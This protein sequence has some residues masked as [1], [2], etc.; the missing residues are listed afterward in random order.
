MAQ[1]IIK[2]VTSLALAAVILFTA[3]CGNSNRGN[4]PSAENE[5]R[6]ENESG[7]SD[8]AMGRFV[9]EEIDLSENLTNVREL[10]KFSDGKLMIIDASSGIWVSNDN[11][12]SWQD[13]NTEYLE[14]K[15]T[16]AYIMD[17]RAGED[18]TLGIIYD[19]YEDELSTE[20]EDEREN[21]SKD[22]EEL[23]EGRED[24]N[25]EEFSE[26]ADSAFNLSPEC[27]LVK[28]DGTVIPVSL[29]LT[30]DEMYANRMWMTK[31]GRTF[32][33]TLGNIIYEVKED[34]SSEEFLTMEG[35][36]MLI[37]FGENIMLIDGYDF[38]A[39]LLYDM[40]KK[41]YVEDDVLTD[42]VKEQAA[43]RQFNGGSWY[44]LYY[45]FGEDEKL[46]L[47]GE[48]GLYRHGAGQEEMDQLIDGSLS[49]LGSP[50]YG[51]KGMVMMEDETFLAVFN[52]GKV[53]R[54]TYDPNMPSM[55]EESLKVYS[56]EDSY[57]IRTAIA[58]YQ[59][60]K[61]NVH[62]E[63]EIGRGEDNGVTREDALKKL[64]TQIMA[65]EG[66]D[67]LM[68]DGLPVDSYIEK[69]LLLDLNEFLEDVF[70]EEEL[71]ENLIRAFAYEGS[72]YTIPMQAGFPVMLGR[73]GY[74]SEMKDLASVADEMEK[75]RKDYP[76]N[77]ILGIC[78]E[79]M[80]MKI[81]SVSSAPA[82]K[83]ENGEINEDALAEFLIQMKR[84]Y[85]AQMDGIDQKWVAKFE[86]T[87]DWYAEELGENWEYNLGMYGVNTLDYVGEYTRFMAGMTT[88]PYGYYDI[89][90]AAKT[91]GFEDTVLTPM[92][93]QCSNVF[94]PDT[95]L[96]IN[97]ASAKKELAEDFLKEFLGKEVQ[98][99]LGG[100]GINKE[101]FNEMLTVDGKDLGENNQYGSMAMM[102]EDGVEVYLDVYY[103]EEEELNTLKGWMESADTP[104]IADIV[105]EQAIFEEGAEYIQEN[106]SLEE[107]LDAIRN[108]LAIYMSE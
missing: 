7:N 44:D 45:F 48:K 21:L 104:Y 85:D 102:D 77:D 31:E 15:L 49:R 37:Q 29:S 81:F 19:D 51:I 5:E 91:K 43:D 70:K 97:A 67:V 69:G 55:P 54:F 4:L 46:Y 103:P 26:E 63:Y 78:S 71:Y 62:V 24:E 96:G 36:P 23:Q 93:G 52:S 33:T 64:N 83:K 74:V 72:I 73:E 14:E 75:I 57:G 25:S 108:Q 84:I 9:E 6:E 34:G 68:M 2:R 17:V 13:E 94:A 32:V 1:K 82:W 18:G 11:G 47:A 39:P 27:A 28:A 90:S 30:E 99:S 20:G 61:P 98:V 50:L 3:G 80:L 105:F 65:G 8:I 58:M 106:Q 86:S 35:R 107:T 56:L 89:T 12:V 100:F 10:K 53:V 95:I 16:N 92:A 22:A 41:E 101:A 42:F 66:P 38:E 76:E 59:I 79:K 40:E 87:S 88:Y 60:A